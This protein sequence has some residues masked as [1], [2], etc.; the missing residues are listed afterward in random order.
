MRPLLKLIVAPF[1]ML[2]I[3]LVVVL[4]YLFYLSSFLLM[5]FSVI[6]VLLG[7]GMF[8]ASSPVD[9]VIY[10]VIAFLLPPM[11]YRQ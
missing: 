7:V 2:L 8:F 1:V 9:G 3:V 10:L 4:L 5:A 6:M 11:V